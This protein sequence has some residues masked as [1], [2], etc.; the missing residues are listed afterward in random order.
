MRAS[1]SVGEKDLAGVHGCEGLVLIASAQ[2]VVEQRR[3]GGRA[4]V[5]Q[6]HC[7]GDTHCSVSSAKGKGDG[8]GGPFSGQSW[9][10]QLMGCRSRCFQ[11]T[12]PLL[13]YFFCFPF[14]F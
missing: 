10:G 9:L 13:F 8:P 14:L 5:E 12:P 7:H 4:G 11:P 2:L 6:L 1:D 3:Q